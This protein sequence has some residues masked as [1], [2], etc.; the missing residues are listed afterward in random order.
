MKEINVRKAKDSDLELLRKFEQG[1]ISAERPFDPTLKKGEVSYYDLNEMLTA[2]HI[3]LV[4]A[5]FENEIIGCGYARIENA[6]PYLEHR[7]HAYLGFMY[8]APEHR[9]KGVNKKVI[10]ELKQWSLKKNITEMRLDLY[11]NNLPAINAYEKAGFK[12]HMTVMRMGLDPGN[13]N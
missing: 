13:N 3:H 11:Y 1:V 7:Q 6:E 8:T 9:G 5:E 4:V 12:K 10:D 2:S